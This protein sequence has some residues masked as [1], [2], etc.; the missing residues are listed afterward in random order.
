MIDYL[1]NYIPRSPLRYASFTSPPAKSSNAFWVTS[2][3]WSL[4]ND[5]PSLAPCSED[6]TQHSHSITA[7]PPNP[8]S[9]NL[10]K[11]PAKSTCPSPSERNLPTLLF[12]P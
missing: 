4:I 12:Q 7:Q 11:M 9:D 5:A 6:L 2:I 8:Y 1:I 10:V 3:M